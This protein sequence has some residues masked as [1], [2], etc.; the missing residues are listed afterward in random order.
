MLS[1]L[2]PVCWCR[3]GGI[4]SSLSTV[5]STEI[6]YLWLFRIGFANVSKRYF[7]TAPGIRYT[8]RYG[9]AEISLGDLQA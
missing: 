5:E 8:F 7:P 2:D 3:P 6:V 1:L 4:S 9:F